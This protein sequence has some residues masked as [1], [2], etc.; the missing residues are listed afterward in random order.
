MA[1]R[2]VG[3]PM[4]ALDEHVDG[5]SS[6]FTGPPMMT[7]SRNRVGS[8]NATTSTEGSAELQCP[9]SAWLPSWMQAWM[10]LPCA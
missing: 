10:S 6:D 1:G 4:P 9:T 7:S 3:R 5:A 2:R 8:P